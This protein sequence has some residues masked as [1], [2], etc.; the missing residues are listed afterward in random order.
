[1]G[2][3]GHSGGG[4]NSL[5]ALLR[6]PEFF[7]VAV[8]SAG[9]HDMRA[10]QAGAG[11]SDTGPGVTDYLANTNAALAPRLEGKLLLVYGDM[12]ENCH[13]LHTLRV[14]DALIRANKDF[15]LLVLPN[16]NH[17]FTLDPYFIRRRWDYFVRHLRG[18]AP[19]A[20]F[21]VTSGDVSAAL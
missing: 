13:P 16:R 15:D 17:G 10:Y 7:K 11:L 2:I 19:P 8:S 4:E 20:D 9:S 1:M 12:D 6:F 21:D 14:V 18:E 5:K 3:C